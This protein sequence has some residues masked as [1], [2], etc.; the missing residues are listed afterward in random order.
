M[1]L[2]I[3]RIAIAN[4]VGCVLNIIKESYYKMTNYLRGLSLC[5]CM[6]NII[7]IKCKD[8]RLPKQI[9]KLK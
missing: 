6:C 2:R 5:F 1:S 3:K 4:G 9:D 8:I 7:H